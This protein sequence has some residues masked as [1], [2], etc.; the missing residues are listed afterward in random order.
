M[1]FRIPL[2][3]DGVRATLEFVFSVH[4][5][6]TVPQTDETKPDKRG[7]NIAPEALAMATQLLSSIPPAISD[8]TWI[9]AI[10]PQLFHLLDGKEGAELARVSA[11][12]TS[13]GILGRRKLGAP[14]ASR[15]ITIPPTAST[16]NP[17]EHR[18]GTPL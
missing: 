14:G 8:Q 13:F 18:A 5:S 10:T 15:A 4:P 11:Y 6:G 2:R 17:Q 16:N 12:V 9:D 7:A 1:L 3:G